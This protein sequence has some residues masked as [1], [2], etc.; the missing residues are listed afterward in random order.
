[1][2]TKNDP[3]GIYVYVCDTCDYTTP[4]KSDYRRHIKSTKHLINDAHQ[5]ATTIHTCDVCDKKYKDRSGLWRH[6]KRGTCFNQSDLVEEHDLTD[7]TMMMDLI[8]NNTDIQKMILEFIK[9]NPLQTNINNVTTNNTFNLN[10][11]LNETCKN[12]MNLTDFVNSIN[13]SLE[14]LENTGKKGYI[15]GI[16]D[17]FLNNLNKIED[18]MRPIHCSN[19]KRETFYIKDN[20]IWEKE[21]DNKPILSNA[22][23]HVAN[24]NIK[25]ISEWTKIHPDYNDSKSKTNDKYLKIVSNSMNGLTEEESKKNISKIISNVA[26]ETV[27]RKDAL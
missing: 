21:S 27:I 5:L 4:N 9:H 7:K 11:Y 8:K 13:L 26:K 18:T 1:M 24:K 6:K 20:D 17:I 3:I 2:S 23:K 19:Q 10:V 12:A 15:E 25:Q 22:I 16:S 14:D